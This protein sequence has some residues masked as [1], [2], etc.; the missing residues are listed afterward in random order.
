M[1]LSF[2]FM[3]ALKLMLGWRVRLYFGANTVKAYSLTYMAPWE[4]D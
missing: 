1:V 2:T 4:P 3:E